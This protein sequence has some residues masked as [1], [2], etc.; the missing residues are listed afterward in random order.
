MI[1]LSIL[2]WTLNGDTEYNSR[3]A[4]CI[5]VLVSH[6]PWHVQSSTKYWELCKEQGSILENLAEVRPSSTL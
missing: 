3:S 4:I 1:V 5:N 6:T 2:I